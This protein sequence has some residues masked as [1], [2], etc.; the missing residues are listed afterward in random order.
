MKIDEMSKVARSA[1]D[2]G[3]WSGD[4]VLIFGSGSIQK[5]VRDTGADDLWPGGRAE[6]VGDPESQGPLGQGRDPGWRPTRGTRRSLRNSGWAHQK[7][8]GCAGVHTTAR[9]MIED[10][11]VPLEGAAASQFRRLAAKLNHFSFDRPDIRFVTSL[12]CSVAP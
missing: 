5:A 3:C 9:E 2:V 1:R 7:P 8:R 4:D 11:K 10:E 12:V 6:G